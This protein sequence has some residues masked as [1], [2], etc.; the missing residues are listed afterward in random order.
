VALNIKDRETEKLAA[1][2]AAMTGESKT[3]AVRIA[4]EERKQRLALRIGRRDQGQGLQRFLEQEVWPELPRRV[5]GKR[6]TRRER[7][8]ILGYGREGV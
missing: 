2:V 4:L 1:E 7:D 3:R 8:A 6:V 5:L